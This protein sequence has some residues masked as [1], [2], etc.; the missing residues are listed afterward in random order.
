MTTESPAPDARSSLLTEFLRQV[1]QKP[2]QAAVHAEGDTIDFAELDR[3]S[4]GI[5]W[6][7]QEHGVGPGDPVAIMMEP[8][9]AT[10]P[11]VL[12]VLKAGGTYVPIDRREPAD[13]ADFVLRDTG[14]TAVVT[15]GSLDGELGPHG[16]GLERI[17]A[18]ALRAGGPTPPPREIPDDPNRLAY[19]LYT[20]GS[21]GRPKGVMVPHRALSYYVRWHCEHLI[22]A[23]GGL[24]LPLS[25]S[26][27]FAAGVTQLYTPLVTGRPLYVLDLD[28]L[29]DPSRVFE[30]YAE[31]PEFGL[32][33]VPTLWNELLRFASG[34]ME[35]GGLPVVPRCVLLSGERVTPGLVEH[36]YDVFPETRLWN[37][38][39]PT[40]ATANATFAELSRR[41]PVTIGRALHGTD[42]RLLSD[43]L[44]PVPDGAVGE[45]CISGPG[46]GLGYSNLPELTE[47]RFVPDPTSGNGHRIFRTGDMG[48]LGEDGELIYLGR[49]D[50]QV[51]IRGHRVECGEVETVLSEHP[52]VRQSVVISRD[53][54]ATSARL[55]AYIV[56]RFAHYASVDELRAFL[57]KRLPDFMVPASYVLLNALPTLKNGKVDRS[58]LP[59][60]GRSR[61]SLGYPFSP[62]RNV[63][64][65]QVVRVWEEVLGVEGIGVHDNFFDLGGD[66]L[67]ATSALERLRRISG[68]TLSYRDIFDNPTPAELAVLVVDPEIGG[69]EPTPMPLQR[70]DSRA[71]H[72]CPENQQGLWHVCRTFP[73]LT[74]YNIQFSVCFEGELDREALRRSVES[75]VRRHC[76]LRTVF[77]VE[78]GRPVAQTGEPGTV[79]LVERDLRA[80]GAGESATRVEDL[81]ADV[82]GEPFDL[83]GGPL[84]RFHLLRTDDRRWQLTMTVHH[85]VFDGR[86][87]SVFAEELLAGYRRLR[88]SGVDGSSPGALQYGDWA[89]WRLDEGPGTEESAAQFWK[90]SLAGCPLVLDLPTDYARPATRSFRGARQRRRIEGPLKEALAELS[91]GEQATS[92]MTLL[93]A[94]NLLL[95]RHT[96]QSDLLVG[97]PVANREF[98]ETRVLIGYFTN[99]VA[100]RTRV[101]ADRSFR[102]LVTQVRERCLAAYENQSFPFE[103]LVELLKPDRT[104]GRPPVVQVMFAFHDRLPAERVD[105]VLFA[106]V[107]EDGNDGAK[108]DLSFD[109]QDLDGGLEVTAT[110]RTDLFSADTVGRLLDRFVRL[111]ETVVE[112]PDLPL[113]EYRLLS[114]AD[115]RLFDVW[116]RTEWRHGGS[117]RLE[118]A[119]AEQAERTPEATA[120]VAGDLRLTYG[121][122]DRRANQ[123]AHH[124][125]ETGV[126]PG[127]PVGIHLEPSG[128]MVVAI[129]GILKAGAAYVPLDPYYPKS[130]IEYMARDSGVRS[131]VTATSLVNELASAEANHVLMDGD[132]ALIRARSEEGPDVRVDAEALMYIMY[133][134]GSSGQPKGVEVNGRGPSNYVL[135]MRDR[136]PL[137][138]SDRV[139]CRTSINFDISVWEIFLPL[140]SGATLV[141]GLPTETQAPELLGDLMR[142][143]G[144]TQAQFVPSALRAFVDSGELGRSTTLRR[145]FSGGEALSL[146]LQNE[147]FEVFSGELHNLYGPTEAS[148]YSCH[149]ECRRDEVYGSV[150]IGCP[151]YNTRIHILG[152]DALPVPVGAVGEIYIGGKGGA[153]GYHGMPEATARGFVPDSFSAGAGGRLFRTGDS[154]RYLPDGEIECLGRSD[155]LVKVR[156]Y[157]IELGEIEH[158]LAAHPQ[159]K[160]AIII[161]REDSDSDVRLV[162]YLLYKERKGPEVDELRTYL[163]QSLPDYMIPSH[164]VTLDSIPLLPND[165]ADVSA[166]PKPEYRKKLDTEL[167]RHYL[168][169]SERVLTTVWEEVLGHGKFGPGDSF[170]EVGGHSLLMARLGALIA[171]RTGRDVSN[172]DLFQFPTI[173]SL[174]SHLDGAASPGRGVASAMTRRAAM[175]V[176]SRGNRYRPTRPGSGKK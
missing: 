62:P 74:A 8:G 86:S 45:I 55:V 53:D 20:S 143:E 160:H 174:A 145:L 82:R 117:D 147:V 172:I 114:D 90:E 28:M 95:H 154:G 30:W 152:E 163:R 116:N 108:F 19:I 34:E 84:Y 68:A 22:P 88:R 130:R 142:R 17:D 37:L 2:G 140:V 138:A 21:S 71:S 171:E 151:I 38:Y 12:G 67:R 102:D 72:A 81:L 63:R 54:H 168:N 106:T 165:K 101:E 175:A 57:E 169:D 173:R 105:E 126:E 3:W 122:L 10:A 49:R 73:G 99:T 139:L 56:F 148:I 103:R 120:L 161:V 32:Y 61:P 110:Y 69:D 13:R 16:S 31:H 42:V 109:V 83:E 64:E 27:C 24:D 47:E 14:A 43:D 80:A 135:W 9:L 41:G 153:L 11:A 25:S 59:A 5:A 65:Q 146:A 128:D 98:A 94:F 176:G 125:R 158:H 91:R 100:V 60:P 129:L 70:G 131:I 107:R 44:A 127:Q 113:A 33:C 159:V 112:Q 96:G 39:G 164:F 40:E 35:S 18:G 141:V 76:T 93:A 77:A 134:S 149:W 118:Q 97:T 26:I 157:R 144:I 111:V 150:P 58:R 66:S 36:S 7:L 136:F 85:M 50:F 156:G 92:F 79:L 115:R 132:G 166:L 89:R 23:T 124:L 162:A 1:R 133:T 87:I 121:A 46:L 78:S 52:A 167:D 15:V 6:R 104:P 137:S 4:D 123:L 155:R 48:R 170:F 51:Q 75:I 29:R 119:F